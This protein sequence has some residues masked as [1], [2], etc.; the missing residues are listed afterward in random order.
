MTESY[1]GAKGGSGVYQAIINLMPPHETYVEVFRGT[2]TIYNK[3]A[4]AQT[5]ILID[6]SQKAIDKYSYPSATNLCCC[7]I[8]FVENYQPKNTTLLYLDP[9]YMPETRTSNAKYDFEMTVEDHM[10][11]LKAIKNLPSGVFA[12]LSGYKN[13]LYEQQLSGWWSKDFQAMTRGGVRTETVWC[14][15][16]PSDIHYHAYAGE[17]FTDRQRIQRKAARWANNFKQMPKAEQQAVLA[18][19]LTV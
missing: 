6:K 15:F 10:R 8:E 18:A 3:K 5:N 17:N 4:P 19:M 9:P 16:K 11:L 1:L 2:A 7:G 14:N 13:K 12:I